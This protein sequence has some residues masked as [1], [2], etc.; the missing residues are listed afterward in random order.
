MPNPD[1][2]L[3]PGQFVR[4]QLKGISLPDALTVPE[5][6]VS[7]GPKGT[8]LY[9]VDDK[10]VARTRQ[11][12]TGRTANGRWVIESGIS[13]GD[14]VIVEGLSK[15]RPDAPVKVGSAPATDKKAEE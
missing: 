8:F 11:I 2:S 13:A 3:L 7:Q 15:V 1:Q 10:G 14:K 4:V 5:R 6:A 12:K 9:V